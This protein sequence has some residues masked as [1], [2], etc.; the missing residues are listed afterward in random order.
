MKRIQDGHN[1]PM[2]ASEKSIQNKVGPEVEG[3]LE[4][5][6]ALG[7]RQEASSVS[8]SATT[9]TALYFP[10]KDENSLLARGS[11]I[12]QA[13][14]G[15]SISSFCPETKLDFFGYFV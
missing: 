12:L 15:G 8:G 10:S 7:F 13:L 1:N 6:R 11:E 9:E 5:L 2:Y 4:L 3:W 14:L